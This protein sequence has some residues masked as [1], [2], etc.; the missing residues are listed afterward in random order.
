M[1]AKVVTLRSELKRSIA[2][3]LADADMSCADTEESLIALTVAISDYREEG[4][5][6]F[7]RLLICD[8]LDSVLRNVQ[9]SEPIEIGFGNR[10]PQTI[11]RALK[12][13]G[14][15]AASSWTIWVERKP[16]EFRYGVFRAPAPTAI[17]LRTTLMATVSTAPL[18]AVMIGQFAPGTIEL[19]STGR[20]G[21]R[22]HLTGQREEQIPNRGSSAASH[23]V[24]SV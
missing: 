19:V 20:E 8:D 21:I 13:C 5:P 6:L 1:S 18:R 9:G 16:E 22:I 12:K 17:D 23:R 7:P 15:L 14:P 10:K 11:L 2:D 3:F 4:R 24:V